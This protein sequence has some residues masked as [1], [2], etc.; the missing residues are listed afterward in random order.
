M[1]ELLRCCIERITIEIVKIYKII[2]VK[3]VFTTC[4]V[5]IYST[6]QKRKHK[7]LCI[8]T[9]LRPRLKINYKNYVLRYYANIILHPTSVF[10]KL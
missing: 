9:V 6:K 7:H 4:Y 5:D 3:V 8:L 10:L 1:S 2:S